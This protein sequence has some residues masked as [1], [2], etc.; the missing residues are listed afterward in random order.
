MG[1]P[2]GQSRHGHVSRKS[3]ARKFRRLSAEDWV[4]TET[5]V[6]KKDKGKSSR[7]HG[8]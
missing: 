1:N 6:T 4:R 2:C 8:A 7:L 5:W 3:M